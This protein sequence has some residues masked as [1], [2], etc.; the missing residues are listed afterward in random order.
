[1]GAAASVGDAAK[2]TASGKLKVEESNSCS[3]STSS[4]P[5]PPSPTDHAP[6]TA[7]P[8]GVLSGLYPD[9]PP[10]HPANTTD[11]Q[12]GFF[13]PSNRSCGAI[14][15]IVDKLTAAADNTGACANNS[16]SFR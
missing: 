8:Q 6:L 5:A 4:F 15:P 16:I 11:E 14:T 1:M 12:H 10:S 3:P 2:E 13:Y 9:G 7:V